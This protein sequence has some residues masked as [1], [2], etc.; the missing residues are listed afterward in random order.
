VDFANQT[1]CDRISA[2]KVVSD[3]IDGLAV[4]RTRTGIIDTVVGAAAPAKGGSTFIP[5]VEFSGEGARAAQALF[6]SPRSLIFDPNGNLIFAIGGRVCRIDA[7]G[8]LRTI[9]GNGREGFSGDGGAATKARIEAGG[10]AIDKRGNLFITEYG[11]NRVRR[12]DAKTGI[13]TTIAGN[14]LPHRPPQPIM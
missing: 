13:I 8:N 11:S 12:V 3:Q 14:G 4:I 2:S 9:A 1:F 7:Q 5:F 6:N 10:L